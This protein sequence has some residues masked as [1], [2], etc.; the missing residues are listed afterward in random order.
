MSTLKTIAGLA[1]LLAGLAY[2][3]YSIL[4]PY[5]PGD[6]AAAQMGQ[7]NIDLYCALPQKVMCF[8]QP[9]LIELPRNNPLQVEFSAWLFLASEIIGL[10]LLV[11]PLIGGRILYNRIV[12]NRQLA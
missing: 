1:L 4:L 7:S 12:K 9:T 6:Y 11:A 10:T 8:V 3:T 5:H 2:W